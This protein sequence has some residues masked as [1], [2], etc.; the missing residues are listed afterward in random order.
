[1]VFYSYVP[2][3]RALRIFTEIF[4]KTILKKFWSRFDYAQVLLQLSESLLPSPTFR[5]PVG[6]INIIASINGPSVQNY[7]GFQKTT[8]GEL[9][10]FASVNCA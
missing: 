1:M 5:L 6:K 10:D 7:I 8:L 9:N 4:L 3:E 2:Y